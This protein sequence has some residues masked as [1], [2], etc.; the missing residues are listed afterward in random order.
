MSSIERIPVS[1]EVLDTMLNAVQEAHD[2]LNASFSATG[3]DA[4]VLQ[5]HVI[6]RLIDIQIA[7]E[8]LCKPQS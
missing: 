3:V 7:L 2:K 5:G 4:G 1:R 8:A 6:A